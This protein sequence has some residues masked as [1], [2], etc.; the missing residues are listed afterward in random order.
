MFVYHCSIF[1]LSIHNSQ[2]VFSIHLTSVTIIEA[3]FSKCNNVI[4]FKAVPTWVWQTRWWKMF[5]VLH[6]TVSQNPSPKDP[7]HLSA[8]P[9]RIDVS[10]ASS[11]VVCNPPSPFIIIFTRSRACVTPTLL[12]VLCVWARVV[13]ERHRWTEGEVSR[14]TCHTL[15]CCGWWECTCEWV[16]K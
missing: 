3:F 4:T 7:D 8:D 1:I 5:Y 16:H 9:V 2:L 12:C 11:R 15:F 10:A 6:V 14:Q 13:G